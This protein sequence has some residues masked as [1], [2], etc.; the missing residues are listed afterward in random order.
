MGIQTV[1]ITFC[2]IKAGVIAQISAKSN[3]RSREL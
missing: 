1:C 3:L 2:Y